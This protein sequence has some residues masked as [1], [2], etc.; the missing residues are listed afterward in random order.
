MITESRRE[1]WIGAL[2]LVVHAAIIGVLWTLFHYFEHREAV[3][4]AAVGTVAYFLIMRLIDWRR[5][6]WH[7]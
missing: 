1:A 5:S 6:W 7:T 4:L 3:A 2:M